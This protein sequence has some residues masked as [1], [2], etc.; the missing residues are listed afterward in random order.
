MLPRLFSPLPQPASSLESLI[1]RTKESVARYARY[2]LTPSES[3]LRRNRRVTRLE[4]ALPK[5]LHLKPFRIRTYEKWRGGEGDELLTRNM[6][7]LPRFR[8]VRGAVSA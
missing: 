1:P 4:S 7:R 8:A 5:S 2:H 6:V 3:A